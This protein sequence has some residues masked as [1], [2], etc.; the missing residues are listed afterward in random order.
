MD[1]TVSI[2]YART[3]YLAS[4]TEGIEMMCALTGWE[5]TD[6]RPLHGLW[7]VRN[8]ETGHEKWLSTHPEDLK[9]GKT[10]AILDP[11]FV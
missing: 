10:F 9:E 5:L 6:H 8:L 7:E 4:M 3:I 2:D 11:Y 1:K